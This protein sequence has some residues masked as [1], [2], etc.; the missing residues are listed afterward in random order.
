MPHKIKLPAILVL[1]LTVVLISCRNEQNTPGKND[2][3]IRSLPAADSG[4]VRLIFYNMYLPPQMAN[5]FEQTG[6]NYNPSLLNQ[7]DNF[8][9]YQD[10]HKIAINL[11]IYGVDM[12]YARMFN[13]ASMT[14]KYFLTIQ[15]MTKKLG[16]PASYYEDLLNGIDQFSANKDSL[17]RIAGEVYERTDAYLKRNGRDATAA[18]IVAGGWIEALYISTKIIESDPENMEMIDRIAEQKYSLNSLI[19]LLGNYQE[20]ISVAGDLL[21]LKLLKKSFDKFEIYYDQDDFKLDTVNKLISASEYHSGITPAII[22]E[23][24]DLTGEIRMQM[25]N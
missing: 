23:V 21:L 25:I 4:N 10:P 19:S 1:V 20:D 7:S 22:K 14:A 11:G 3:A 13:Q 8:A 12:N 6:A 24:G 16:I 18:L 17:V 5:I 2:L 15:M 9:R